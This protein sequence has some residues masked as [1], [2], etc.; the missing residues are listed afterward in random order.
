MRRLSSVRSGTD[1]GTFGLAVLMY[2][3][4]RLSGRPKTP[5]GPSQRP[6]MSSRQQRL[7]RQG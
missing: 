2:V 5:P 1:F 4:L 3:A 6:A 7:S